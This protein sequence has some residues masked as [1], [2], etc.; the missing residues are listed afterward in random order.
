[1]TDEISRKQKILE[2]IIQE[3]QE[4]HPQKRMNEFSSREFADWVH[5]GK[6]YAERILKEEVEAGRIKARVTTAGRTY[7]SIV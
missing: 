3:A 6:E 1:M 7:Y 2:E 4:R 5:S